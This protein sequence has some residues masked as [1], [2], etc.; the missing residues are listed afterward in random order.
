MGTRT[1]AT[2]RDYVQSKS[3]DPKPRTAAAGREYQILQ[4]KQPNYN[5]ITD[6]IVGV[7]QFL[8]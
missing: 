8:R 1:A 3:A 6:A 2:G 4:S 5:L 7:Q